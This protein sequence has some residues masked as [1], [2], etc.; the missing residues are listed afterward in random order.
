MK[1]TWGSAHEILVGRGMAARR[2]A[3]SVGA[4][5]ERKPN[6]RELRCHVFHPSSTHGSR[7]ARM[8][9]NHDHCTNPY[10]DWLEND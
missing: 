4:W 2:F 3:G 1:E 9:Y 5:A 7:S 10:E 8:I 6:L